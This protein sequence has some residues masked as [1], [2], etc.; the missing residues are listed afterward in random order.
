M[1]FA[2]RNFKRSL[3]VKISEL[4][5]L[6]YLMI[7]SIQSSTMRP[8]GDVVMLELRGNDRSDSGS[9]SHAFRHPGD[10]DD[11]NR[12]KRRTWFKSYLLEFE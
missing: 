3:G 9:L 2:Y 1:L 6:T 7:F 5:L 4:L 11:G 10:P 12:Q 8:C